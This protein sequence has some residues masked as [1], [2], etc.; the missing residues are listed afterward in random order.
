LNCAR[1][2]ARWQFFSREFLDRAAALLAFRAR[3]AAAAVATFAAETPAAAATTTTALP[4][5]SVAVACSRPPLLQNILFNLCCFINYLVPRNCEMAV[6]LELSIT[7]PVM[8]HA[9]YYFI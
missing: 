9:H 2:S 6:P 3:I 5:E 4:D 7:V 8:M 1:W